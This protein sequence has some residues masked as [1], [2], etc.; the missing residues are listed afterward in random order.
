MV[1]I[2][3]PQKK[4]VYRN[5]RTPSKIPVVNQATKVPTITYT[6]IVVDWVSIVDPFMTRK[7]DNIVVDMAV[8][9]GT[10]IPPA[11]T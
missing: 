9:L 10:E 8:S 4:P 6:M 2:L 11:T 7:D 5:Y 3:T 1:T